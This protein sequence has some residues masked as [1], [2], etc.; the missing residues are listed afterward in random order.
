VLQLDDGRLIV[1]FEDEG[2]A[3]WADAV[4]LIDGASLAAAVP[5]PGSLGLWLAGLA[6]GALWM[7][8]RMT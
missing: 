1:G 8:R 7:R 4:F 2:S 3:D 6:F 5:E